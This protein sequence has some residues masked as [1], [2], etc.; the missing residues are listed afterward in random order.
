M[1]NWFKEDRTLATFKRKKFTIEARKHYVSQ[2]AAC[3]VQV[4]T[5]NYD[6]PQTN[7]LPLFE[8]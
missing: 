6:N 4:Y 2:A 7:L 3:D 5:V 1:N 8:D